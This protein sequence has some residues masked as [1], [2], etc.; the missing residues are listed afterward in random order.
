MAPVGQPHIRQLAKDANE[1]RLPAT[2]RKR[3]KVRLTRPEFVA[4][5]PR[6][7]GLAALERTPQR[8]ESATRVPDP[9]LAER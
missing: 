3:V 8:R 4:K 1:N 2:T 5:P 9:R 7:N 6:R